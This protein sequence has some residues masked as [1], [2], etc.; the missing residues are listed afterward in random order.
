[1]PSQ[2]AMF[3]LAIGKRSFLTRASEVRFDRRDGGGCAAVGG[4]SASS[5]CPAGG[6]L[7]GES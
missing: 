2:P 1:M 3:L 5:R 6:S 4:H 7:C